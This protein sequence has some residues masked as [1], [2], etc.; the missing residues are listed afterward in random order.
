MQKDELAKL[1]GPALQAELQWM[2]KKGELTHEGLDLIG[3]KMVAPG[4]TVKDLIKLRL[5]FEEIRLSEDG[6]ILPNYSRLLG[7]ITLDDTQQ[8][9][10]RIKSLEMGLSPEDFIRAAIS[11]ALGLDSQ[12]SKKT[13]PSSTWQEKPGSG[14]Y[15][16]WQSC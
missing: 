2:I 13:T 16:T 14:I 7:R 3:S 4:I 10:L 6:R 9:A 12:Q 1:P 11:I 8:E 15:T 5:D